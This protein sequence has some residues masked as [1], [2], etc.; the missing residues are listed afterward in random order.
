VEKDQEHLRGTRGLET[1]GTLQGALQALITRDSGLPR[2]GIRKTATGEPFPH[3]EDRPLGSTA[4][5]R[6]NRNLHNGI[7]GPCNNRDPHN[8]RPPVPPMVE[9]DDG[10]FFFKPFA[11]GEIFPPA[12]FKAMK[13]V[14]YF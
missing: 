9:D 4:G 13:I 8:A 14:S 7:A 11:G 1:T 2:Q 10:K 12:L 5:P 3:N 6:N